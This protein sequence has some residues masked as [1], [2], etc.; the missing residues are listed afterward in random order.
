[1]HWAHLLARQQLIDGKRNAGRIDQSPDHECIVGRGN[2]TRVG[3][4]DRACV[5][6]RSERPPGQRNRDS[7][8]YRRQRNKD[9]AYPI[10]G[11]GHGHI[12][13]AGYGPW[14]E[15][16]DNQREYPTQRGLLA[17]YT[18]CMPCTA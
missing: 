14:A 9:G 13:P 17:L 7:L 10:T 8:G 5:G 18:A 6:G 16:I 3:I 2:R 1:V 4:G 11:V 12:V 15:C